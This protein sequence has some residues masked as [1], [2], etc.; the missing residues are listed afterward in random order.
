MYVL[1][2]GNRLKCGEE[3]QAH[4]EGNK[5][6]STPWILYQSWCI[7]FLFFFRHEEVN[8]GGSAKKYED[9]SA[10]TC[11]DKCI[12]TARFRHTYLFSV[13]V[14]NGASDDGVGRWHRTVA[15]YL[16]AFSWH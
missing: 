4:D 10:C 2:L 12:D 6:I 5:H 11:H 9:E 15:L 1:L 16:P 8:E 3:N 7:F 13:S 14:R